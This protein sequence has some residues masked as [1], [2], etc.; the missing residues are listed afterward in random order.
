M[1]EITTH[2]FRL[3]GLVYGLTF[4]FIPPEQLVSQHVAE[5]EKD[6]SQLFLSD[7]TGMAI[8]WQQLALSRGAIK[9]GGRYIRNL[10]EGLGRMR[11]AQPNTEKFDS[12]L[13]FISINAKKLIGI[14]MESP[15]D[16]LSI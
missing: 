11:N 13:E 2:M 14:L 8:S 5:L 9:R 4:D 6:W 10:K 15:P 16:S 3:M 1:T 7:R 12:A